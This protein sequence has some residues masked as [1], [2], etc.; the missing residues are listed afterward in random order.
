M[1]E[2]DPEQPVDLRQS[3]HSTV[4]SSDGQKREQAETLRYS[5]TRSARCSSDCGIDPPTPL[6]AANFHTSV[7]ERSAALLAYA[8]MI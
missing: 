5:I 3:G 2:I 7:V 1:T 6:Q 4:P 8:R